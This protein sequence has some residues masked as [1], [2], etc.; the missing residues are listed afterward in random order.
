ML[1]LL[2]DSGTPLDSR[3]STGDTLLHALV[4]NARR[5]AFPTTDCT[6]NLPGM[7]N[8]ASYTRCVK[9]KCPECQ[10][11]TPSRAPAVCRIVLLLERIEDNSA[12]SIIDDKSE[13][14]SKAHAFVNVRNKAGWTALHLAAARG[15]S[16]ICRVSKGNG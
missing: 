1:R 13:G 3:S 10:G 4:Y 7:I 16:D 5:F 2:L 14:L 12:K 8:E 6:I 9:C 15:Y 11:T